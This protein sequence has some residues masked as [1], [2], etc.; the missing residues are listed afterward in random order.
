MIYQRKVTLLQ[1]SVYP[2]S[3]DTSLQDV[4]A[5]HGR[6]R[7]ISNGDVEID[8]RRIGIKGLNGVCDI[9]EQRDVLKRHSLAFLLSLL[10]CFFFLDS[11]F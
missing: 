5:M 8:L 1:N 2:L 4:L 11:L 10:S 7:T 3:F 6:A 9:S